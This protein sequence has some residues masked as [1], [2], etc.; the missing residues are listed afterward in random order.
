MLY[1]LREEKEG[2][3][4]MLL[5]PRENSLDSLFKEVRVFKVPGLESPDFPQRGIQ[6]EREELRPCSYKA[7]FLPNSGRFS[8]LA[9]A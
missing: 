4:Q 2:K 6:L 1:S 8:L 9:S 7:L 3:F 5:S